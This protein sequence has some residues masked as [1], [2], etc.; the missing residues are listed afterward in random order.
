MNSLTSSLTTLCGSVLT[1]V[2]IYLI[3]RECR[4]SLIP[5]LVPVRGKS[6]QSIP[7]PVTVAC[8]HSHVSYEGGFIRGEQYHSWHSTN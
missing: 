1:I 2:G 4:R 8:P 5:R 6:H 3:D 7:V